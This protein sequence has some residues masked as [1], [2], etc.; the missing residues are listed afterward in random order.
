M[1]VQTQ[2]SRDTVEL[3]FT[4]FQADNAFTQDSTESVVCLENKLWIKS[5]PI[6]LRKYISLY[7]THPQAPSFQFNPYI[8]KEV[9]KWLMTKQSL[10]A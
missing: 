3:G 2:S 6:S 7:M 4:S 1:H 8:S 9:M 5:L 10:V